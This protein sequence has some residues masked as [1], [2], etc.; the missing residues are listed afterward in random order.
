[1]KNNIVLYNKMF[2]GQI[3]CCIALGYF[4]PVKRLYCSLIFAGK[5][6]AYQCGAFY[7]TS[8][9]SPSLAHKY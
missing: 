3:F 4:A 8:L 1:M 7:E 9:N 5:A 6:G 2:Y